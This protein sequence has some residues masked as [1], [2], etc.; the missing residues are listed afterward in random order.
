MQK[1][2]P[3][4]VPACYC[5]DLMLVMTW[6]M[7]LEVFTNRQGWLQSLEQH[8]QPRW[9]QW[10]AAAAGPGLCAQEARPSDGGLS[11]FH[12]EWFGGIQLLKLTFSG[13]ATGK[14]PVE[15][16]FQFPQ[17]LCVFAKMPGRVYLCT[18]PPTSGSKLLDCGKIV[19]FSAQVALSFKNIN[20]TQ[21]KHTR[22]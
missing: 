6:E 1:G 17:H 10:E 7:R 11:Q 5:C 3:P 13:A 15:E 19:H 9:G 12:T 8:C 22:M 2:R 18:W 20:H 21:P 14:Y 4:P 16:T